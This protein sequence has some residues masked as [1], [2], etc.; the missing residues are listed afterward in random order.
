MTSLDRLYGLQGAEE[1][2]GTP[3]EVYELEID[4]NYEPNPDQRVEIE[5]FDIHP[6]RYH[7][8]DVERLLE[9][10]AEWT[11]EMGEVSEGFNIDSVIT[12]AEVKSAAEVLLDS[13]AERITYR[14]ANNHL[15]SLWVTW[16]AK[17]EPMLDGEPMYTTL[18]TK[19]QHD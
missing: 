3:E 5:E 16:D 11:E 7:L 12:K 9:W 1:L 17:G 2:H 15:R 8:P 4:P 10:I 6:P 19:E 14:M 13:I 18:S